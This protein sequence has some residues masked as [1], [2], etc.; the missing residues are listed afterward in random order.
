MS[1][2]GEVGWFA[3]VH[4]NM[5]SSVIPLLADCRIYYYTMLGDVW[6]MY[7]QYVIFD[8]CGSMLQ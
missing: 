1:L 2:Y 5:T 4:K 7:Q 6:Y 8:E 3:T